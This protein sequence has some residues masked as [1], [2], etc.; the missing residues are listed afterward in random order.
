MKQLV[1]LLFCLLLVN[2]ASAQVLVPFVKRYDVTQPG[3]LV[4][5]GNTILTCNGGAPVA[6][7]VNC[8]PAQAEV[9]PAGTSRDN[10][11]NSAYIDIDGDAAT[12]SSSS[13]D[14]NL[15]TCSKVTFAGLYWAAEINLGNANY[16][17]RNQVKIKEPGATSYT[18]LTA[19]TSFD[20]NGGYDYYSCY[21]DI[22]TIL[23]NAGNGTYTIADLVSITGGSNQ[24]AG[25]GI[26]VVY[27]NDLMTAKNLTV[28]D[29]LGSVA[30]SASS[31]V[32]NVNGFYTPPSGPVNFEL[33]EIAFDGDRNLTGDSL[34]FKGG[35]S[36]LAVSDA[37]HT[38][39]DLFNSSIT[40][41]AVQVLN[42]NPAYSNTLGYDQCIFKPNNA[43]K[44]YLPNGATSA[45]IKV[46]TGGEQ[47]FLRVLTS[48]IDTYEPDLAM[49]KTVA[50]I[51]GGQ[52]NPG[53][54][55]LYTVTINNK[56]S[57]TSSVTVLTD[58]LPF[59]CDYI[60]GSTQITSGP[61]T[62]V[63]TDAAGDDQAEFTAA[64]AY[65]IVTVRLGNGADGTNGG[66]MPHLGGNSTTIVTFKVRITDDC[67]KLLCNPVISNRASINY[68]GY[69]SGIPRKGNSNPQLLDSLGCP[70]EGFT[71]TTITVPVVCAPPP[72]ST[73]G[74]CLPLVFST[75][76]NIRPNYTY[77]NAAWA[78]VTQANVTGTYH[79]IRVIPGT[80]CADTINYIVYI[81][82][83]TTANAGANQNLCNVA[84]TTM[85]GNTA[86]IGTGTW[87]VISGPNLPSFT[88]NHSPNTTVTGLIPGTYTFAWTIS[89]G[90]NSTTDTVTISNAALPT[91][92]NAGSNQSLCNVTTATFAGNTPAAGTGTWSLV[93]GPN[94]PTITSPTSPTSTVTG[95]VAGVYVFRWTI[96]NSVCTASFDDVQITIYSLPTVANAGAAQNLCNVTSTTLAGNNATTG[97]GLWTLVSG[98]N[99]PSITSPTIANTGVTGM[100]PGVYT[101]RWTIS[102]GVCT[103]ST[104]D[105]VVTIYATS[106]IAAAGSDQSL[107]NVTSTTF[108][109][110]TP[111]AGSGTWT[112]ISGPNVPTITTASSPTSTV[113][114]LITGTYVFRWTITNG[115]CA[116]SSD[117]V[118]ISNYGVPTVANAGP[119]QNL[120]NVTTTTFAGNAPATGSGSW[121]L[122]SGPNSPSITTVSS[123]TSTVTG[124]IAG[125]YIFRWTIANGACASSTN[126]VQIT[127]YALPTTSNAGADQSL[128][129]VTSTTLTGNNPA[130]GTGTWTLISGPNVPSISSPSTSSTSVTGMIGGVYVFRWTISNGVCTSSSDDIQ[131]TIYDPSTSAAAGADQNL[132]NVVTT[133]MAANTPAAGS[134]VWTVI[135]GPNA[136]VIT[137][138][139]SPTTTITGMITGTYIL[140]WT[141]TNGVC[142]SSSDDIQ[143]I[144][145]QLPTTSAAGADQSLC[146]VTSTTLAANTATVGAG[147]WSLISGPNAPVITTPSSPTSTVTGMI[148][149]VYIFRW[150]ISNGVCTTSA[151]DIQVTIYA[152]PTTAAAGADQSLCNVT[153]ATLAGNNPAIG[154]G[155]WSLVSGPN[156]PTITTPAANNSTVTGMIAGVYLFRWTISNGV[157]ASSNDVVQVTIYALPTAANAGVDQSL[158]NVT[159][160]TLNANTPAIG[161][162]AWSLISGPNIPT[163]TTISSPTSTVTG[164]ITG[165][166]VFRWTTSNGVCATTSDDVQITIYALPTVSNAGPDQNLC[167]VTTAT[168]AGN[169]ATI[170]SGVWTLISGPNVPT[171]TTPTAPNS[172]VTGMVAGVYVFRWSISNGACA[173][174][175]D[176]VQITIY[177]LP[178]VSNAGADQSLCNVTTTTF[179][180]NNPVVG[181]GTWTLISGP[182]VPTIT[183]PT[184]RNSTITGMIAGV[185]VFRWTISNGVCASSTDDV[186]ITI[187]NL[188][189][190]AS[191]GPDQNL[192]SVTS[193]TLTGNTPVDGT[194]A[195]SFVSGPNIPVITTPASASTTVTGMTTGTYSFNW[196]I[197]NGVCAPSVATVNVT[198]FNSPTLVDAG[199]DQSLC[200]VVSTTMAGN[201]PVSGTGTWVVISGPNVPT[202]TLPNDPATTITGLVVG[203][204]QFGWSITNGACISPEDTITVINYDLP[205]VSNAGANQ[206]LCSVTSVTLN[207]NVPTVGTGAWSLVSGP[208]VP[209]FVNA[210][211]PATQVTGMITGTYVFEWTVTSGPCAPSTSTIQVTIYNLPLSVDAGPNQD[212]CNT[213]TVTMDGNIPSAGTGTWFLISGP[214]VPTITAVNSPS[215]TITG[216]IAGTYLFG[217]SISNGVCVTPVD[218]IQVRMYDL[219]TVSAAGSDQSLCNIDSTFLAGNTALIGSGIWTLLSGPNTP[220]FEDSSVA[221]TKVTGLIAGSYS[222]TW[223]I[224][225]GVCATSSDVVNVFVYDLPTVANAGADQ[226]LC[227]VTSTTMTANLPLIGSG[228]WTLLSGPNVPTITTP[229]DPATTITGL[230]TGTYSFVWE[231]SNGVC[232]TTLDTVDVTI[233]DLPTAAI[234]GADQNLC[235]IYT[236]TFAATA[237]AIGTGVWTL[238]SGPN[239]PSIAVPASEVTPVSGLIAGTYTF[240]WTV[241]NG[242]C[243]VTN[244]TLVVN[245]YDLP[246]VAN[247]GT[248]QNLCADTTIT[249]SANAPT[250]GTALWTLL[251]GPNV[252]TIVASANPGTT[253]T[254]LIPGVYQFEW[255]IS[256]GSCVTSTDIVEITIYQ[257][258]PVIDAGPDQNLC[259]VNSITLSGN[260]PS[261]GVANWALVSGPNVPNFLSPS[262]PSTSVTGIIPGTY[263]FTWNILNGVCA[264]YSDTVQVI[265]DALPT[266]ADAGIDQSI[267]NAISITLNGNAA[268]S[269]VGLWTQLS[270]PNA[271]TIVAANSGT[272]TVN[273]VIAGTYVYTWTISNGFCASTTDTTQLTIYD[274]PLVIDA[275]PDQVYCNEDTIIMAANVPSAGTGSWTLISGP[276]TPDIDSITDPA[277]MVSNM[278]PGIYVF[279]WTINNGVCTTPT[280][281]MSVII[282][283]VPTTANAGSDQIIC[284]DTMATLAGNL[285]TIGT[286]IW[287]QISGPNAAEVNS[288]SD[289][290]TLLE[291]LIPGT[292]VFAWSIGNGTCLISVDTVNIIIDSLP[293]VANAGA[294][295]VLCDV[296]AI[297]LSALPSGAGIGNWILVSGPNVPTIADVND[298]N[299]AVTGLVGGTYIFSWSV[300][301]SSC[302]ATSDSVQIIIYDQPSTAFAGVDQ[303]LCNVTSVTLNADPVTSGTGIWTLISGPNVPAIVA[304]SNQST[305]VNGMIEGAY[306][307]AWTISNGICSSTVDTVE[308]TIDNLPSPADAGLDQSICA[309]S[310]LTL[311]GNNPT[312]GTGVWSL[313]NGPNIPSISAPTSPVTIV[314]GFVPGVYNFIWTIN[315]GVCSNAEDTVQFTIF[316]VPD[317]ADAGVNQQLCNT[318]TISLQ[319][320]V[321]VVGQG[322]WTMVSGPNLPTILTPDSA[323]TD[324]AGMITGTYVFSWSIGNGVCSPNSSTVQVIIDEMPQGVDAGTDQNLC[325][326]NSVELQGNIPL[327]GTAQ[328]DYVTGPSIPII[329][330]PL[331]DTTTVTSLVQGVYVFRWTVT[332]GTC[333]NYDEVQIVLNAPPV[334][335]V[336]QHVF[337]TCQGSRVVDLNVSGATTYLWS[338]ASGLSNAT[339]SSPS[340]T[341]D[342]AIV[343]VVV[344]TDLNGCTATDSVTIEICDS[345]VI[346]SGFTPDGDG[347][348]DFFEIVGI[349]NYGDNK[350]QIFNRWGNLLYEKK[351]YDNTWNGVPNVNTLILGSDKVP[352]GTYYYLLELGSPEKPRAG[353]VIIKY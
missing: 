149:G 29:G 144:N 38:T 81:P 147:S 193:T 172:G 98:P 4:M 109:G 279:G 278:V 63:K 97:S 260:L 177:A 79:G 26:V 306:Q 35:A 348:N 263:L 92:A 68:S 210:A 51:D 249:L 296:N 31:V 186:T 207:G 146:N 335:T 112:L 93:S 239:V 201:V 215:S 6:G 218:T 274:I 129:N 266:T 170:G 219:P 14:L 102:N 141:I 289:P 250:T 295:Q 151:D 324:V 184:S 104:A 39:N 156:A 244:D 317:L 110:N 222:F 240:L 267:C 174:T 259:N 83:P 351:K 50:D 277:T 307:F 271:S 67:T 327:L 46:T 48:A 338:P 241:T 163:I 76:P 288:P 206:D 235:N 55:L 255:S 349:E 294:D 88:S 71:S 158:C 64:G 334:V 75:I 237:P 191:V 128:C 345:L 155:S 320:N 246:T 265:V 303:S 123:P 125:V 280:D 252:P 233:Y 228:N 200:N 100:I 179:N 57:D 211:D 276:N 234:A 145:Y 190:V 203:T 105:V 148:A 212:L 182:N 329:N 45:Q 121:S 330:S 299:T 243:A 167:N 7:S 341:I 325:T 43:T 350:L 19:D 229:S 180:G 32:V 103:P 316:E 5:L 119:D 20:L 220:V 24:W 214:N 154:S 122:V 166:Y 30:N 183:T 164:M 272:T 216:I 176:N 236:T 202:I 171:I 120:C 130:I 257:Y 352:N 61:N 188:P 262:S 16:A 332:N 242:V 157:C 283:G 342:Q 69:I 173:A 301:N 187:Y 298:E 198:I 223:T 226:N 323:Q 285:P 217:W 194:G 161:T 312:S 321:P 245:V 199:P 77:Y 286:G 268:S 185:Y 168:L 133:T 41:N 65:N 353:Y 108:A 62:G 189:T 84:S 247:A 292:Y 293:N 8:G 340:V 91:T 282:Y 132:C 224:T 25:W 336:A 70:V 231:I 15:T 313:L 196:T 302:P 82:T 13:A 256:N 315:N 113:T 269:G 221:T 118:T 28:F 333:T 209:L 47:I 80:S 117:D 281:S 138:P 99:V 318:N 290:A 261:V 42:R 111:S 139:T 115:V 11:F 284:N 9:P 40:N 74:G 86:V 33:G 162:G 344:G 165:V 90:C 53:D 270:G 337:S 142:P 52:V 124:L 204:Y 44:N 3:G 22:T 195:W 264:V 37:L 2:G 251:S 238:I 192:C 21:K 314:D 54:T 213:S 230:T 159:G 107:C 60:A 310:L 297:N 181:S 225:N 275:G 85:A 36:F 59:N 208:N 49:K 339:S 150:T 23:Q 66:S 232:A 322:N 258:P 27:K 78:P 248:D 114:G 17:N 106:T 160:T 304:P 178:T 205:T 10:N 89:T 153:S 134:G 346:P 253:V 343:Y 87:T 73:V 319:G 305:I 126:D 273:G 56:G 287:T 1:R 175:T 34:L 72:D 347:I 308:I 127:V 300:T 135:S 136:P 18:T 131:V 328:W 94:S 254:G 152:L 140:R 326:V 291:G 311:S 227:N 169:T 116:S 137:T 96:S 309:S 58:T 331:T 143:L 95:M 101:F 197:T 12:F